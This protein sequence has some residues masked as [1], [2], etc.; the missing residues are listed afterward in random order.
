MAGAHGIYIVESMLVDKLCGN[1]WGERRPDAAEQFDGSLILFGGS[2]ER[3]IDNRP[4]VGFTVVLA[5]LN[6]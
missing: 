4:A 5:R 3:S 6:S 2:R 1:C